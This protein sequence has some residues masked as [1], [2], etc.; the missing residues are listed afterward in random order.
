MRKSNINHLWSL[1]FARMCLTNFLLFA[2]LYMLLPLLPAVMIERLDISM[3]QLGCVFLVFAAGMLVV[4]PFHAYLGDEYKRKHVL[5]YST[6]VMLGATAGYLFAD[7]YARLLLLAAVQGGAFGLATTAGIT[8]AIDITNSARRS[9][10]NMAYALAARL[11]MLAGVV[12]GVWMFQLRGFGMTVYLSA[13]CGLFSILFALRVYVA[14]RAPIG[15][16]HCNCDRF[17]LLRGWVPAVNLL[18]IAFIS[19][20][21]LP[22]YKQGDYAVLFFLI[23]LA[24]LTIPF[25]KI[26][27]K[28][29]HH[30]QRGTA[31]T[32]CHL[33]METG[34]LAG[35]AVCCFLSDS[36]GG[37]ELH[38]YT[39]FQLIYKIIGIGILAALGFYFLLTYPYYKRKRVR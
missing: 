35:I 36:G 17:L 30:C 13:L 19:G 7:T 15:V 29:S 12:A 31:N 32:T 24:V 27:V 23:V 33:S 20:V 34:I 16:S 37:E 21:A 14:F 3:V 2:S 26:F 1:G 22:L 5:V 28:L 10:G 4:G 9:A 11:G 39:D 6:L 25:T 8:V 38:V 18:L